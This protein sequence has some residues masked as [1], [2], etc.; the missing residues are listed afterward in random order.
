MKKRS[1]TRIT[2]TY[3]KVLLLSFVMLLVIFGTSIS[4]HASE[5]DASYT[6]A[7][8]IEQLTHSM[9]GNAQLEE[10]QKYVDKLT[11]HTVTHS[12]MI[13]GAFSQNTAVDVLLQYYYFC[14][15]EHNIHMDIRFYMPQQQI[16]PDVELC[17]VLGNLLEN[18][19]DA[20][21]RISVR[22][23]SDYEKYITISS[24]E[25][26]GQWFILVENTYDGIVLPKNNRY[27]SRKDT[28][29]KRFGIGLESVKDIVEQYN[30]SLDIYPKET[31]FRVGITLPLK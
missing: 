20:C 22:E 12:N 1:R 9:A 24:H 2:T 29:S 7:G 21:N 30:G 14:A 13:I 8:L 19:V 25:T 28:H 6:I 3:N 16:L 23:E 31:V 10:L 5:T 4:V 15:K 17:T 27:L 26:D 11:S 18:A